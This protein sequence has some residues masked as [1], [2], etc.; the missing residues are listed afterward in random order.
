MMLGDLADRFQTHLKLIAASPDSARFTEG[1]RSTPRGARPD[2]E[3][4]EARLAMYRGPSPEATLLAR[5]ALRSEHDPEHD[6]EYGPPLADN[7]GYITIWG[8]GRYTAER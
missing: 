2:L 6:P 3:P 7:I 1:R 4:A 5:N 8:G